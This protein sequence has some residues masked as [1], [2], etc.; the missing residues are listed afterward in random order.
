M[1]NTNINKAQGHWVLAKMGKKVL[2]PGGRELTNK[3]ID[4]LDISSEDC[5]AEFAPGL[6]FTASLALKK[7]PKSYIG[8]D[9][10]EDVIKLLKK[11][12]NENGVK[13]IKGNAS[14]TDLPKGQFDKVYGEAMLTMQAENRKS[15]IISE[16][17]RILKTGGLYGIH[18]LGLYPDDMDSS[19]KAKIQRDL[20]LSIQ[21][22][23]RPLTVDEW[24][25]LLVKEGFSIKKVMT[26]N[27]RLLKPKRMMN[28]EGLFRFI[29]IIFNIVRNPAA[30]KRI[31]KMKQTFER[32]LSHLNA[33]AIVAQKV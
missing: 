30:R 10:D 5:I 3:L 14:D 15:Q 18:E 13:F 17:Y 20:A 8:I 6:G 31:I 28:D 19:N 24:K 21:V 22:N 2:R 33:V 9:K 25:S 29:K 16:A 7:H 11:K 4:A 23:A 26:G 1:N 32:H 27:M 12:Y